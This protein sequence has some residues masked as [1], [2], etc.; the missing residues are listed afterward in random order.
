MTSWSGESKATLLLARGYLGRPPP[1]VSL[2]H[3]SE[4]D[5]C[6]PSTAHL[7]NSVLGLELAWLSCT[8]KRKGRGD[9]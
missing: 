3:A 9:L 2:I 4:F 1:R 7:A 5:P 6:F 8:R